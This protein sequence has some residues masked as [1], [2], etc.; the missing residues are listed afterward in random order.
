[1]FREPSFFVYMLTNW[2]KTVLYTGM[3]NNLYARLIEHWIGKE[4]SFTTRYMAHH[5]VWFEPTR[6]VLN[7]IE[8]EKTIKRYSR[9]QKEAIIREF[10]PE[11]RFLNEDIVGNWPPTPEQ[12]AVVKERQGNGFG[13]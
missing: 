4:N 1:M 9:A 11:W 12:I 6:Y 8:A 13:H 2:S 10:N 3:T 5:L 7:A